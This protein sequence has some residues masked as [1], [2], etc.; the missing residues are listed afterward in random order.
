[1][2]TSFDGLADSAQTGIQLQSNV[3]K[4]IEEIKENDDLLI[5]DLAKRV[6]AS[7]QEILF[8]LEMKILL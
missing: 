8:H 7:R 4:I 1:M 2:S 3:N 5:N 6:N